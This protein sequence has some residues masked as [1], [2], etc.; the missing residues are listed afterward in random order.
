MH[1]KGSVIFIKLRVATLAASANMRQRKCSVMRGSLDGHNTKLLTANFYILRNAWRCISRL[2]LSW[3][4]HFFFTICSSNPRQSSS[5]FFK[6]TFIIRHLAVTRRSKH[7]LLKGCCSAKPSRALVFSYDGWTTGFISLWTANSARSCKIH[8]CFI[9]TLILSSGNLKMVLD[10]DLFRADK[11][12]DPEK[13]R[14]NQRKRFKDVKLVDTIIEKDN[15]WRQRT[16]NFLYFWVL[17]VNSI[18]FPSSQLRSN[19]TTGTSWRTRAARK[20]VRRWR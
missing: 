19:K 12:G 15:L 6:R 8:L 11:G 17:I 4:L 16:Y 10:V 3:L 18:C 5:I 14:E 2:L 1:L 7:F 13:I 20:L 9:W